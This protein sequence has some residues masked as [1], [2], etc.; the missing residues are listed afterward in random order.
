ML[1]SP[2]SNFHVEKFLWDEDACFGASVD[3]ISSVTLLRSLFE[4]K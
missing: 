4:W 3:N 2:Q 1:A